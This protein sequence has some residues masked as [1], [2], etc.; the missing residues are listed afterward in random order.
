[1]NPYLESASNNT[2]FSTISVM[3]CGNLLDSMILL[4][5]TL[6]RWPCFQIYPRKID[7]LNWL[8]TV[9]PH[10]IF[11]MD[12]KLFIL[13]NGWLEELSLYPDEHILTYHMP[14]NQSCFVLNGYIFNLKSRFIVVWGISVC[15]TYLCLG[16]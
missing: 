9:N 5:R 7:F 11:L 1:M 13:C 16:K 3:H 2:L 4:Y 8:L 12:F 10:I 14:L 6:N 15:D